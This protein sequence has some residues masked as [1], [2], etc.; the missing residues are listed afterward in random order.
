MMLDAQIEWNPPGLKRGDMATVTVEVPN[1]EVG[2]FVMVSPSENIWS[3]TMTGYVSKS[4][5]V[6]IVLMSGRRYHLDLAPMTVYVR[7]T[8]R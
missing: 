6:T 5:E 2:D 1:A 3:L 7:V 8:P 4:N